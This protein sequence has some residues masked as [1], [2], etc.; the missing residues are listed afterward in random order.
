[1]RYRTSHHLSASPMA[2]PRSIYGMYDC[3]H[4]KAAAF[5]PL[6]PDH[7]YDMKRQVPRQRQ[8]QRQQQVTRFAFVR[9]LRDVFP[10]YFYTLYPPV[11]VSAAQPV[12]RYTVQAWEHY[13][14]RIS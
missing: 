5:A 1:M 9:F 7:I 10:K 12:A 11:K 4:H 6:L 8:V 3:N 14:M 13:A 2:A